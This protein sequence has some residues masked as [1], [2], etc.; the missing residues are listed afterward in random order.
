VKGRAGALNIAVR[1]IIGAGVFALLL[2][3]TD[4]SSLAD[5]LSGARPGFVAGAVSLF[6]AGLGVS[7]L[8]WRE[9]LVALEIAMPFPALYRLY[10]VGT[11]FNA[12]LPTGIGGDAYKAIRLGRAR[13]RLTPAFASVFLDR[14]AGVVGLALIGLVLSLV[15][16]GQGDR[17][18]IPATALLVSIA[19]LG[20]AGLLLGPGERLLGRRGRLIP[21]EGFGGKIRGAVRAVHAAG[22]HPRAAAAGLA[23]GFVF[24]LTVLAYHLTIARALGITSV[25]VAAM[26]GIV[27]VASVATLI[28]LSISGLGFLEGAYVWGLGAYGVSHST[29]VAFALVVRAVLLLSS[30]LGGLVYLVL[31]GEIPAEATL[32]SGAPGGGA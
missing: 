32:E 25:P 23:L 12:F 7:A 16:L 9:Y 13:G 27:V 20:A 6:L 18:R 8:R 21:L 2:A 19:I 24:Q 5:E 1:V 10:F 28:P 3:R 30:A 29:A 26:S 4:L 11:F 15:R 31:G 14:F 22:R 17:S